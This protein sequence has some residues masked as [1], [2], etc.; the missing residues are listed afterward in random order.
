MASFYKPPSLTFGVD[1]VELDRALHN[2]EFEKKQQIQE[3]E[4]EKQQ[5][6]ILETSFKEKQDGI[7]RMEEKLCRIDEETKSCHRQFRQNKEQKESQKAHVSVLNFHLEAKKKEFQL[8]TEK[9]EVENAGLQR[10]LEHYDTV[11]K[12]YEEIYMQQENAQELMKWQLEVLQQKE[13]VKEGRM[14]IAHLQKAEDAV[15]EEICANMPPFQSVTDFIIKIA[16][17]KVSTQETQTETEQLMDSI[18]VAEKEIQILQD[19]QA[20][21]IKKLEEKRKEEEQE[22]QRMEKEKEQKEKAQQEE[23][24]R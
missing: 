2:L 4:K 9:Y 11:W 5:I 12:S 21:I 14:Q 18:S 19:T 20:E 22:R 6:G 1:T 10:K 23:L 7:Q 16:E 8:L 3:L 24:A 15:Q 13:A 17:I